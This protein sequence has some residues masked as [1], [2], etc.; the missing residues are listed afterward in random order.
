MC[1]KTVTVKTRTKN[2]QGI[3]KWELMVLLTQTAV[4]QGQKNWR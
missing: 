1:K 2:R 3:A 4:F